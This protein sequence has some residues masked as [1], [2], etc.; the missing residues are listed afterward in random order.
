MTQ[1]FKQIRE[2]QNPDTY[3]GRFITQFALAFSACLVVAA[4]AYLIGRFDVYWATIWSLGFSLLFGLIRAKLTSP[5]TPF[6]GSPF[7]K[8]SPDD[9]G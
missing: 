5:G 9:L 3:F 2:F 6:W 7:A 4:I 8:A 1:L